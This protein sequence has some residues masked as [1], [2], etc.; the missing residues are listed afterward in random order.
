MTDS[1]DLSAPHPSSELVLYQP[2]PNWT[3]YGYQVLEELGRHSDRQR[4]TYLAAN[5]ETGQTVVI[6][7]WQTVDRESDPLDYEVYLPEIERLNQLNHAHIPRYL[8]SFPTP[9]GFCLVREYKTGTPLS[10][11]GI[12][13]IGDVK[14]VGD[15]VLK[16]LSYLQQQHPIVIHHNIKPENIIVTTHTDRLEVYLVDF[17][18]VR[19]ASAVPNRHR[20]KK[21]ADRLDIMA[22]TPGFVPPERLAHLHLTSA[23]D[24]YSLGVTLICL[25]TGTSS[26]QVE[27][28]LDRDRQ[29][30]FEHL[31]PSNLH[32]Q[33]ISWLNKMVASNYQRR[34][35][36]AAGARASL[37]SISWERG[38][39]LVLATPQQQR[40]SMRNIRNIRNIGKW[41]LWLA[42]LGA[43]IGLGVLA[44]LFIFNED[45]DATVAGDPRTQML[46]QQA[47]FEES[48]IGRLIQNKS[49]ISC[50]L[51]Y[52]NFA[53]ADLSNVSLHKSDLIGTNFSSANLTSAIFQDADLTG[54]N[55]NRANL[56]QAA[57][58]GA[59]L[60]QTD[61]VGA[62]LT[63]AKLVYAK[64]TRA[65]LK[66]AKLTNA[67]AKFANF[68]QAD[69][70]HAN[71]TGA[72]LSNA[73]L[74]YAILRG[75][76][77]AGA[78]L[79][80]AN[81]TG[82]TMPDGSIHP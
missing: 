72:D 43:T 47:A 78:K 15:G 24:I 55:L 79:E 23:A 56:S 62:N 5:L 32:P 30:Q 65:W 17:S 76:I 60:A 19:V 13:P 9:T 73:D 80:G 69:L 29:L 36:D 14:M 46:K 11:V 41:R 31:L 45:G 44:K 21:T 20:Q 68:Q 22:G 40:L 18:F 4:M 53:K 81:L 1:I 77:V 10:E 51:K 37:K 70:S 49:C 67:D 75:A 64:L 61:L 34:Y 8:D 26:H 27:K 82:T 3:N 63:G 25:L 42:I 16:I 74:S 39:Q 35:L 6:K 57:L 38:G 7:Q 54:A 33:F 2:L 12:L 71:L 58:Y 59:K 48:P 52:Q 50:D 66:N 28:L